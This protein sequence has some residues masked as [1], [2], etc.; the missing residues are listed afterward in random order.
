M[1]RQG[2]DGKDRGYLASCF[3]GTRCDRSAI[4]W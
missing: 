4:Q 1:F 2:G 3:H